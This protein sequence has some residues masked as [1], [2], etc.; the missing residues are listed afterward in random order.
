MKINTNTTS[1]HKKKKKKEYQKRNKM[2]KNDEYDRKVTR[3]EPTLDD[4]SKEVEI[5]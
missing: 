3:Y 4:Y 5:R 2:S 1:L